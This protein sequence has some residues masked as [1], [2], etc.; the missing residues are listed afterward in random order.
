MHALAALREGRDEGADSRR[1]QERGAEND[2]RHPN[3]W[4][5]MQPVAHVPV[6]L[7]KRWKLYASQ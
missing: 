2:Q 6:P 1:Q 7:A 4:Q 3:D 5:T